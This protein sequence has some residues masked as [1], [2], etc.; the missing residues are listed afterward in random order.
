MMYSFHQHKRGKE[1]CVGEKV[2]QWT[3]GK[4]AFHGCQ[5]KPSLALKF[6]NEKTAACPQELLIDGGI[7]KS[8]L[9]ASL[10]W[11]TK[12]KQHEKIR[13]KK[14]NREKQRRETKLNLEHKNGRE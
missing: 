14:Q 6:K 3:E 1:T 4:R 11:R 12:K 7:L 2:L 9:H 13:K 10:Q 8:K 5:P